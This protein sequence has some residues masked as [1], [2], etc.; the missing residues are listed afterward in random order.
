[1]TVLIED[2]FTG[3][4]DA[5]GMYG[6]WSPHGN[7]YD[8]T[9]DSGHI[10]YPGAFDPA[11]KLNGFGYVAPS[12]PNNSNVVDAW[13]TLPM[14]ETDYYVEIDVEI[15][16]L[17][18]SYFLLTARIQT[19]PDISFG[20]S[21]S[22]YIQAYIN[23]DYNDGVTHVWFDDGTGTADTSVTDVAQI[24]GFHTL[25]LEVVGALATVYIDGVSVHSKAISGT[26]PLPGYVGFGANGSN[27]TGGSGSAFYA[28]VAAFRAGDFILPTYW[29]AFNGAQETDA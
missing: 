11:F 24:T 23:P 2:T 17:D 1:M 10:W 13:C 7:L 15:P 4:V 25:R 27:D 19:A 22:N 18:Y 12:F 6:A 28:K 3:T 20:A 8:H 5:N 16:G 14:T 9:T 21:N 29:T 26:V